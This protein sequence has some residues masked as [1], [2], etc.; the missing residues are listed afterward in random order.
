M[1]DLHRKRQRN[2]SIG[3]RLERRSN[4]HCAD[5]SGC[6]LS[7]LE[8]M[9]E[10]RLRRTKGRRMSTPIEHPERL[11][12]SEAVV[13]PTKLELAELRIGMWLSFVSL[14]LI[15]LLAFGDWQ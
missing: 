4:L 5:F 14:L 13:I 9:A 1:H 8:N 6:G 15:L 7:R 12:L 3:Q 2:V 10:A 11:A